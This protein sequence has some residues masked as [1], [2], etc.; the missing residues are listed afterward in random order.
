MSQAQHDSGAAGLTGAEFDRLA[1]HLADALDPHEA[2][3]VDRLIADDPRW[4][5]AHAELLVADAAVRSALAGVATP[6]GPMP[7]DVASRLDDALRGLPPLTPMPG[8]A[9]LSA[10]R[11]RRRKFA[12]NVASIAAAIVV[13]A[14]GIAA[15][16]TWLSGD[17]ATSTTSGS[18]DSAAGA[19][20]LGEAAGV[21]PA[22]AAG[23]VF[24]VSGMNYT[25]ATLG[26]LTA[27][28]AVSGIPDTGPQSV[29]KD[30]LGVPQAVR[31]DA[32]ATLTRLLDPG[33]LAACLGAIRTLD[34][35]TVR[36]V[37][38][39]RF[40]G[41]PALIVAVQLG[42]ESTVIAVGPD[43]GQSGPDLKS[44]TRVP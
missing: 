10:A 24:M 8:V 20:S 16:S 11:A 27:P 6:V 41:E 23:P 1:D 3:E 32:P 4:A 37:D 18:A 14:G 39:A 19:P 15:A 44:L 38:Y 30:G 2:A 28:R 22:Y 29:T 21:P 7:A 12:V 13:I 26:Q 43:C 31:N 40:E 25:N 17:F 5:D 33:A 34:P 36:T 42:S 9:S 35:G